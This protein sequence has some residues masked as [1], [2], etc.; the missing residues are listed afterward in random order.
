MR[1]SYNYLRRYL[2]KYQ[3]TTWEK[4]YARVLSYAYRLLL[5]HATSQV[6]HVIHHCWRL[7]LPASPGRSLSLLPPLSLPLIRAVL[8]PLLSKRPLSSITTRRC[9]ASFRDRTHRG[10]CQG[11]S[12]CISASGA[13]VLCLEVRQVQ[14]RVIA[15]ASRDCL[16]ERLAGKRM[17]WREACREIRRG[18][19]VDGWKLLGLLLLRCES[20]PWCE[21]W[22]RYE[23]RLRYKS[24]LR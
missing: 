8:S 7:F 9:L 10:P 23:S 21:S 2:S 12:H 6:P 22:L 19:R 16:I 14:P 15:F 17:A 1:F 5:V 20:R 13:H 24:R 3:F 4:T 18:V 11:M